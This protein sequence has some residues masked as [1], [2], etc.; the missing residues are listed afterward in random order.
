MSTAR[1]GDEEELRDVAARYA[2]GI[3]T[4]DAELFTSV[5]R[6]DGILELYRAAAADEPA[7]RIEGHEALG[8]VIET[9]ARYDKT[10]HFLGQMSFEINE[11]RATGEVYCIANHLTIA[12]EKASN[13]VMYIRCHD[14]YLRVGGQWAIAVRKVRT[15]WTSLL[16]ARSGSSPQ[17]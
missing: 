9:V 4:R 14:E 3:D 11:D 6:P 13:W 8:R 10:F 17:P 5:F 12:G 2:R 16:P 7:T 15:D 1:R